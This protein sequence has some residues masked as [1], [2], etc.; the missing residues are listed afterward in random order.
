[1]VRV[2]VFRSLSRFRVH[3]DDLLDLLKTKHLF[4]C[5]C[6]CVCVLLSFS[7]RSKLLE[8]MEVISKT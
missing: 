7:S 6:V 2:R 1:M 8:S 3:R 5:V 4:L